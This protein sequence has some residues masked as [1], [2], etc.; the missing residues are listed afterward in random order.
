MNDECDIWNPLANLLA[1][2]IEK[3][4]DEIQTDNTTCE[5]DHSKTNAISAQPIEQKEIM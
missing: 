3:Y 5:N 2:L 4:A 1:D